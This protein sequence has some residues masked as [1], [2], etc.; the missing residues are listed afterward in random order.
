MKETSPF[1]GSNNSEPE[2]EKSQSNSVDQPDTS[3]A[4]PVQPGPDNPASVPTANS[5]TNQSAQSISNESP[6]Q[7][8]PSSGVGGSDQG[9]DFSASDFITPEKSG[10]SHKM[11]IIVAVVLLLILV[12]AGAFGY[13]F[14]QK[15]QS[16]LMGGD[17]NVNTMKDGQSAMN[18]E[19]K[20]DKVDNSNCQQAYNQLLET[21]SFNFDQHCINSS[22]RTGEYKGAPPKVKTNHMVLIF[23]ASGSMAGQISG[24]TKFDIAKDAAK[25][26][27]DQVAGEKGF[28]LSIVVYGHKGSNSGAQKQVS[29]DGIE[30]VYYLGPV[31]ADVAKKKLDSF[32]A[33]GWTPIA[34]SFEVAANILKEKPADENFIFL[35]SDGKETCGGDPV[36]VAKN[37]NTGNLHVTANVVG[38]DVGGADEAQLKSIAT[39]GGGDYFS[40][41]SQTDLEA[42][43]A[44]HQ[45]KLNEADFKIGRTIEQL[46]DMSFIKNT[47]INCL[48]M[49]K[50]EE[51][52][53]MLDIHASKLAGEQCEQ[54][55][56]Q[57]YRA[58]YDKTRKQIE[59]NYQDDMSTF[60]QL[61]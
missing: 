58:R 33:T 43:F 49:L 24:K 54:Y 42:A 60:E 6:V 3:G 27:I 34:K 28:A 26:F 32:K 17:T 53:M 9:Q 31:E 29:C 37:L 14:Y 16:P 18:S 47:Y 61:K 35:V 10:K 20:A 57:Q 15:K 21:N 51:A 40:V 30:E 48:S 12:A 46:Y 56:D 50:K 22:V 1:G 8:T 4:A 36:A 2:K 44:K 19:M 39:A 13:F 11:I 5:A 45:E 25:K 55:A 23:D 52:S 7:P 59:D 38:F 41:K